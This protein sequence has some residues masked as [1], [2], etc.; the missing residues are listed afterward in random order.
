MNRLYILSI[1]FFLVN[2][3]TVAQTRCNTINESIFIVTEVMP[4][5]S[6]S[7]SQVSSI[8]N[9]SIDLNKY[10]VP[11]KL[12]IYVNFI[13]NCHGDDFN[14]KV[15]KPE[16][17]DKDLENE[18]LSTLE[19]AMKWTPAMQ[20][21]KGVDF[22][23]T[24]NVLI[25]NKKFYII[26]NSKGNDFSNVELHH[27]YSSNKYRAIGGNIFL[28]YGKLN[29][30]ISNFITNPIFIGLNLDFHINRI[31]IQID[32]Y[33]GF[34]KVK[35]TMEF[36]NNLEWSKNKTALHFMGG[37][38]LG[39]TFIN[40]K[41]IIFVP[42]AG[43]GFDLLS[44]TFMVSSEN[45]KNEPFIP[46]YKLGCYFDIKSWRLFKNNFSFNYSDSYTCVRLSFGLNSPIGKPKFEEFY[47]G[48]MIYFTIGMGGFSR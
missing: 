18:L 32:D 41:S 31:V 42:L 36:P 1:F 2:H 25:D 45:Q 48:S 16:H 34:G 15:I 46:Y 21:G 27:S 3:G 20:R 35:K 38:N 8:L 29:G 39:Y 14:Y 6:I 30:N 28:G 23:K 13:I 47:N 17:I 43:I 22:S 7:M 40:S 24:I 12:N 5:S 10:Q 44:S 4:E 26:E 11:N 33:I 19:N 9:T 37:G